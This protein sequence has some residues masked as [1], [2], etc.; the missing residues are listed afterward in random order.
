MEESQDQSGIHHEGWQKENDRRGKPPNPKIQPRRTPLHLLNQFSPLHNLNEDAENPSYQK[1]ASSKKVLSD[2][3]VNRDKQKIVIL[4]DSHARNCA[5]KLQHQL[6]KKCSVIGYVKPGAGLKQIVNSG[7]NSTINLNRDDV[8]VVWGGSN[9]ISK[10]NTREALRHLCNFIESNQNVN[11]IVILAPQRYDLMP[12]SCVNLE[13]VRF[14]RLVRKSMKLYTNTKILETDLNRNCFTKHGFH[15]NSSGKDQT[16]EN[17][18]S[19]ITNLTVKNSS[20]TIELKWKDLG[21]NMEPLDKNQKQQSGG[22]NQD[23]KHE[24]SVIAIPQLN[25]RKRKNPALKDQNFLW[26]I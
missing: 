16:I 25:K 20:P 15:M 2:S 7:I 23:F 18:A 9:D 17:L 24:E 3:A 4:G 6:D 12:S 8:I 11:M 5:T 13:V 21:L 14:N 10:Q 1:K 19:V 26:Q 22:E